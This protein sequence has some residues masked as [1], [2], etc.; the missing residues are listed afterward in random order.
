MH[1]VLQFVNPTFR[2]RERDSGGKDPFPASRKKGNRPV[3]RGKQEPERYHSCQRK[4]PGL[5]K[6]VSVEILSGSFPLPDVLAATI[7]MVHLRRDQRA[8]RLRSLCD[9]EISLLVVRLHVKQ[10]IN[11]AGVMYMKIQNREEECS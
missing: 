3:S 4:V 8:R 11:K 7:D 10:G 5:R 9:A 6:E 2:P 1:D